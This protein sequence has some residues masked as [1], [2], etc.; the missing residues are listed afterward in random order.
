MESADK[1]FIKFEYV[2]PRNNMSISDEEL[3]NDLKR[4]GENQNNKKLSQPI[5][6]K[7][8]KYNVSTII[9]RFGTWN[10]ALSKVELN[11]GNI[12]NYTDEELFDN[13]LNIWQHKGTQPVRR[14]LATEM[15]TISQG[16]YSRRFRTWSNALKCFIEYANEN[17]FNI[18]ATINEDISLL[19]TCR[20]PSLRLRFKILKR[21]K[22]S[23]VNCGASPAKDQNIELHVDHIIPWSKGGETVIDNLQTLCLKCNLGKSDLIL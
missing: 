9:R 11:P 16:P 18:D 4:V 22:F 10:N 1:A 2:H 17:E 5:Y 7:E 15:S 8:G 21:D 13:L 14:D 19:K 3:L 23:C 6:S 20:D 12:C